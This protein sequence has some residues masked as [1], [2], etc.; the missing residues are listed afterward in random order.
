[1]DPG[2]DQEQTRQIEEMKRKLMGNM[3]TKEA[4][5]RL[6]RVRAANPQLASQAELYL[7]QIF[8]SGGIKGKVTDTKMKEVLGLL[9][10]EKKESKIV[11]K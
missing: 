11:R 4:F 7:L 6:G 5:E 10:G 3:L 8:Q 2:M 1:M 9:S